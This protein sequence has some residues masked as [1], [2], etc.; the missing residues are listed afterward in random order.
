MSIALPKECGL[1]TEF[2]DSFGLSQYPFKAAW[3]NNK[4]GQYSPSGE[5]EKQVYL[6][7]TTLNV[8]TDNRL[9]EV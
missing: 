1:P 5:L 7:G 6:A 8:L 2:I 3:G 4:S 9:I